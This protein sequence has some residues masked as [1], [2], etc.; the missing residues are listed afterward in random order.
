[1]DTRRH[2][3]LEGGRAHAAR[4]ALGRRSDA[5]HRRLQGV[6][7]RDHAD[8]RDG[9]RL[10]WLFSTAL[11][12]GIGLLAIFVAV[13]GSLDRR[14]AALPILPPATVDGLRWSVPKVDR[15]LLPSGAVAAIHTIED[16]VRERRAGRDYIHPKHYHRLV[17]RLGPVPNALGAAVPPLDPARLYAALD[18]QDRA[19]DRA[20]TAAVKIIELLTG[21]LPNED[22]QDLD[23]QEIMALVANVMAGGSARPDPAAEGERPNTSVL[24]KSVFEP[25]DPA[26]DTASRLASASSLYASL[27][28]AA[29]RQGLAGE[30]IWR[31]LKIHAYQ[32]DF[33]QRVRAGDTFEFFFDSKDAKGNLG[34]L[35]ATG[36]FSSGVMHKFYRFRTPDGTIDYYDARGTTARKFLMRRPVHCQGA[37]ITSGFGPRRHPMLQIVRMHAGEDWACAPGTPIM[38]AGSGVI[39]EAVHKVELGNYIRIRHAN[40]Y[41][42]AYG[43]M[44]AFAAGM[45]PGISVKQGQTIGL[46]G[47]TG[48]S[49]GPHVHFEVLARTGNETSYAPVDPKLIHVPRDRQLEGK[50]FADFERERDRLD[51]LMRRNPIATTVLVD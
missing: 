47:S 17:A 30:V 22:G 26:E 10:R 8:V 38:A 23:A 40:G 29:T 41:K 44:Q 20:Q 6:Y 5:A 51:E 7:A 2:A 25:E 50:E 48:L 37:R 49:Q 27:H 12:A 24:A 1:M 36:V 11:T 35:L 21:T 16:R 3:S 15:L 45:R 46:V 34:D 19:D 18:E 28:H 33:S 13:M 32:T 42:T 39:E 14:D 4:T 43:H 31:I 9:G